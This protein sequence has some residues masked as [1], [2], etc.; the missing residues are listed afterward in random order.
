MPVTWMPVRLK[1]IVLV[2]QIYL[3]FSP[4]FAVIERY[5]LQLAFSANENIDSFRGS[6]FNR[7]PRFLNLTS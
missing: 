2:V 6:G 5:R 7:N 1:P 4:S 3:K